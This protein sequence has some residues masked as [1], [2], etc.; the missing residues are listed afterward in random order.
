MPEKGNGA[1]IKPASTRG[2]GRRALELVVDVCACAF[3]TGFAVY[4]T[5]LAMEELR[6]G[7]VTFFFDPDKALYVCLA[8]GAVYVL[9]GGRFAAGE[10]TAQGTSLLG[11]LLFASASAALAALLSYRLMSSYRGFAFLA[12]AAAGVAAGAA[13][14]AAS[15]SR[16]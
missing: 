5:L 1:G 4:L 10:R 15:S 12:A 11:R 16:E 6:E 3:L 8:T 14:F 7:S 9:G 13:A 2:T